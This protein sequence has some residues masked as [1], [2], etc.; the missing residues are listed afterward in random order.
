MIS[1][2]EYRVCTFSGVMANQLNTATLFYLLGIFDVQKTS[3]NLIDLPI[4]QRVI[5]DFSKVSFLLIDEG[6][7][8]GSRLFYVISERL[9]RIKKSSKPFGNV[10]ILIASDFSQVCSFGDVPLNRPIENQTCKFTTGGLLLYKNATC[11]L[12]LTQPVRQADDLQY[13]EVLTRIRNK[14]LTSADLTLLKTRLASNL[15][16]DEKWSFRDALHIFSSNVAIE[17]FNETFVKNLGKPVKIVRAQMEPVCKL[18]MI[19][20]RPFY[21]PGGHEIKANITRNINYFLG[22]ANGTTCS[23]LQA[24]FEGKNKLPSFIICRVDSF[25]GIGLD[26]TKNIIALA[27][28]NEKLFCVHE[29]KYVKIK[30]FPLRMRYAASFFRIQGFNLEKVVVDLSA[31]SNYDNRSYTGLTRVKKL[32]QLMIICNKPLETVFPPVC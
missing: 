2:L 12:T 15:S 6:S 17:D 20:Y 18:C 22:L 14:Q 7:L 16:E 1:K 26:G 24:C 23:I 10:H 27:P 3:Q 19:N 13:Y 31:H 29:K 25:K 4:C 5:N 28:L 32:D 8:I 11:K 9:K 21:V 30:H